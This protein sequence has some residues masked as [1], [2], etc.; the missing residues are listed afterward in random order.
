MRVAVEV[1]L[2]AEERTKLTK[3]SRGRSTPARLVLRA[4]IVL[5]AADGL[6]NNDIA[7]SLGCTRRTV[8]VWRNRFAKDRLEGIAQDAPWPGRGASTRAKFSTEIILRTTQELPLAATQW[9]SRSLAKAVGCV[10]SLVQRVWK[11]NCLDQKG[12]RHPR[13]SR[14][15]KSRD[16]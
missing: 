7:S 8:G 3:W 10:P 6:E 13:Q 14:P 15:S 2:S 4:K 1:V 5:A 12:R 11:D 16:R 9:S